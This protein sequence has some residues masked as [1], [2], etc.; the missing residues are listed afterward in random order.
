MALNIADRTTEHYSDLLITSD[1]PVHLQAGLVRYFVAHIKP[2]SF[3]LCI[4]Q[5]DLAGATKCAADEETAN[6]IVP[7]V[8]FLYREA[9]PDSWGSIA[10]VRVWLEKEAK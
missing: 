1:V 3:M 4:L 10:R 8:N 7:I 2:G 6:A 9:P 5:N